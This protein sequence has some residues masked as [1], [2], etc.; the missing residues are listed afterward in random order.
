MAEGYGIKVGD[1]ALIGA[2]GIAAWFS[3]K[4][5]GKPLSSAMTGISAPIEAAGNGLS[6]IF[7]QSSSGIAN[8]GQAVGNVV[9]TA[10]NGIGNVAE[11][12]FNTAADAI[13]W[14]D[15][16]F[17]PISDG[18]YHTLPIGNSELF[19]PPLDLVA[20]GNPNAPYPIYNTIIPTNSLLS[21]GNPYG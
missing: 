9:A 21:I 13:M 18:T 3:Y 6:E 1:L 17:Q 4:T 15:S 16:F 11:A 2:I 5:V 19:I 8:A 20:L 10:I 14:V 7:T 12:G